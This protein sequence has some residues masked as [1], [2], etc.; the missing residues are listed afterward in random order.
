MKKI[1]ALF[2]ACS[3]VILLAQAALTQ[4]Q[5]SAQ[6]AAENIIEEVL[7]TATRRNQTLSEVPIAVSVVSKTDIQNSGTYDVKELNQLSPSVLISST[8]SESNTSARI[9]G[10]GTVGD[11]IGLESSVAIFVDG[12][13]RSRTGVGM[14]ELGDVQ[15]VEVLRGPQGTLFGRNASAGLINITTTAPTPEFSADLSV[16]YGN[17]DQ[18][19][20]EAGIN[21]GLS[22][23]V[24]GKLETILYQRDGFYEDVNSGYELNNR[25]RFFLRGQL[26]IE[27]Q[28]N[29]SLRLIADYT[30]QQEDCCGAVFATDE[31][32]DGSDAINPLTN[33][34]LLDPLLN[35]N[36]GILMA[37][38]GKS[39]DQLYPSL[40]DPYDRKVALSPG[41]NMGGESEKWGLSAELNWSFNDM[42]LTS[43]S[44]YREYDAAQSADAEYH[45][46]D[47]LHISEDGSGRKF[48]TFSQEFRL[49]GTSF[50]E[51][52]NWLV[53][54]Y[55][56]NEELQQGSTLKFGSDYGAYAS[57]LLAATLNPS[58]MEASSSGCLSPTG[59]FVANSLSSDTLQAFDLLYSLRNLGDD[60]SRYQQDSESFAFFTH[61]IISLA[62]HW[63]LTVGLRYTYDEKDFSAQFNNTNTVCADMR[64]LSGGIFAPLAPAFLT[65]AC[66]GNSSSELNTLNLRDSDVNEEFTGTLVLSWQPSDQWLL[67]GSYSRGYKA[68]G[69]NLDRSALGPAYLPR[70]DSDVGNLRFD[71]EIVD[72]FE[73]GTKYQGNRLTASAAVFHQRFENFQ[74]N[75]FDGTIYIVETI[76]GCDSG[77]HGLDQ[78]PDA[79]SG[80]CDSSD[81]RY[82]VV[83]EG[84]ELETSF[85]ATPSL[86][87]MA[88]VT[89]AETRYEDDLVGDESGSPLN[90]SL[91]RLPGNNLSNAPELVTTAAISWT[92]SLGDELTGLF[93]LNLRHSDD[94]NTGSNLAGQKVQ[95]SFTLLNG[96]LGIV[97]Q[98]HNWSLELWGKNLLDE[99]Y[100]QVIFDTAFIGSMTSYLG[101][102]R[103]YGLTFRKSF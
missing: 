45:F 51:R 3:P 84:V 9:R 50:N 83:S 69:F 49:Q 7:V 46:A 98:Q 28:D 41:R 77:L 96:R 101:D 31:V 100:A 95:D 59:R 38:T 103:T 64:G 73:I 32:S 94:Y 13:Y 87:L 86:K 24:A 61:N 42:T 29:M 92:P 78:D 97:S 39:L 35:P 20:L 91:R 81:V 82:G 2:T 44:A 10:I 68:G 6:L 102:P 36:I 23:T 79:S 55:Y 14:G 76:N 26:L 90:P 12:V 37:V 4:A 99:D 15:Q 17:Y 56:A 57:C 71:P 65:L 80:S 58:L 74:L 63:D 27:P 52:L 53:G 43:I 16:S 18:R 33:S 5:T 25:D 30:K 60:G 89:Y 93:Y 67:Y 75:T 54:A 62:D 47:I 22:E 66:Q 1:T 11:N 48:Q 70:S 40:H 19:R 34:Q 21:G 8:G 88:G 85:S 72:A